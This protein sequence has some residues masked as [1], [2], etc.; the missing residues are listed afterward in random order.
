MKRKLILMLTVLSLVAAACGS[1]AN[2][3]ETTWATGPRS[4]TT[5]ATDEGRATETTEASE[6]LIESPSGISEAYDAVTF[7]EQEQSP[8][9]DT[10]RDSL[11]TFAMDVD[12]G[13]YN[14]AQRFISDGILPTAETVRAEEFINALDYH[15]PGPEDGFS[16]HLIGG[17]TPFAERDRVYLQVGL[18]AVR[19]A[20]ED[21]PPA[22]LT[23]VIDVSGSMDREDRL[24]TVKDALEILVEELR[25][26]DQVA[27]VS[28][29]SNARVELEPTSVEDAREIV[30][31]I[32]SLRPSGSTNAEE[33]LALGYDLADEAF[34][35]RAINRVILASDGVANVGVT[36]AEGILESVGDGA[37]RDIQLVT[38]G[39]GM[40]NYNDTFMEQL[41]DQGDG[42][43]G[44]VDTL[45]EAYDLFSDQLTG[46]LYTVALDA[47]VQVAFNPSAV[48]EY[49]LIG[50]ENRALEDD[51]FRDDSVD[52]GEVGAGHS[53]TALYELLLSRDARGA[54]EI[55]NV[56][57]RWIDPESDRPVEASDH[58]EVGDL[59][60]SF[61]DAPA[62][63]RVATT[64]GAFA[65]LLEDNRY[66]DRTSWDDLSEVADNLARE[67]DDEKLDDF[68]DMVFSARTI[69]NR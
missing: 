24:E 67:L 25:P 48:E 15:Y 8:R 7:E 55:A 10:V 44:Y 20:E 16:I 63:F 2:T 66:G 21:R 45:D 32:R 69:A 1:D 19:V 33:G 11:S 56:T 50:Y 62:S 5:W 40:G 17:E 43:Y 42:F 39:F 59:Y 38:V 36:S 52:A 18:Q 12:T 35:P 27:I 29:G 54:D 37:R 30:S 13:S 53:V 22:N 14:I 57:I 61:G 23:F 68:S 34:S 6:S 28:Y 49:R 51:E 64:V 31:V 3:S 4:E 65:E 9:I 60:E 26:S 58:I 46:T 47:K 41:A